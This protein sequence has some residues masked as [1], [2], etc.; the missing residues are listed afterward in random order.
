[1]YIVLTCSW[2]KTPDHQ[3]VEVHIRHA[4]ALYAAL[5]ANACSP[6]GCIANNLHGDASQLPVHVHL[7]ATGSISVKIYSEIVHSLIDS[8]SVV[9]QMFCVEHGL[10]ACPDASP[11]RTPANQ[12][13][14]IDSSSRGERD[15]SAALQRQ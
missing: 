14:V 9:I 10:C 6:K 12:H 7:L 3:H 13:S 4:N 15:S 2:E 1:M 5:D 8:V 11:V